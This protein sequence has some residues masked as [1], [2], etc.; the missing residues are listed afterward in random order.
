M[1][2]RG[3][4]MRPGRPQARDPG[5]GGYPLA[6]MR[7]LPTRIAGLV[8]LE[9]VAHTDERGFFVETYRREWHEACG[10]PAEERFVQ[11]NH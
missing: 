3:P 8:A 9:P 6:P 7:V 4:P 5:A 1:R 2:A 11:D 10:I